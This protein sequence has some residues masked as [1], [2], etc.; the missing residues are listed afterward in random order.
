MFK[1]LSL[2][3]L[4]L[5]LC[6]CSTPSRTQIEQGRFIAA[7]GKEQERIKDSH[8]ILIK[9]R[10]Q[11]AYLRYASKPLSC[12][13]IYYG[14]FTDGVVVKY[15]FEHEGD[16]YNLG[17]TPTADSH[18]VPKERLK[19][20]QLTEKIN[21]LREKATDLQFQLGDGRLTSRQFTQLFDELKKEHDPLDEEL[22]R[23]K[24]S[25]VDSETFKRE[26][27]ELKQILLSVLGSSRAFE[28]HSDIRDES[29]V[30][31]RRSDLFISDDSINTGRFEM[32]AFRQG[33]L[34]TF[35]WD[36]LMSFK[37]P[38]ANGFYA[39]H[40]LGHGVSNKVES[41][42]ACLSKP[43]AADAGSHK[44]P[45]L[46]NPHGSNFESGAGTQAVKRIE[47]LL[48]EAARN[49]EMD[50]AD[51]EAAVLSKSG[52]EYLPSQMDEA[53]ADYWG[54]RVVTE[55]I[56]KHAQTSEQK[57][58]AALAVLFAWPPHLY[59]PEA[60]KIMNKVGSKQT[61]EERVFRIILA[62]PEFRQLLGCGYEFRK[63][64][65]SCD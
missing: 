31:I 41:L 49:G 7:N 24:S 8:L 60:A 4:S 51:L 55:Y 35:P 20:N 18:D 21:A 9:E 48:V 56:K 65:L 37:S 46:S 53:L 10:P 15:H 47:S 30:R 38:T 19:I 58:N 3:L 6:G 28:N 33:D 61:N 26:F 50:R 11:K 54:V 1:I 40:E 39:S 36:R 23:Y 32:G 14:L 12:E 45:K 17:W 59:L 29:L 16:N 25:L 5:A 62:Y 27:E 13:A 43:D 64:P 2:S 63:T 52:I 34:I 44:F 57:R 42:V 22:T